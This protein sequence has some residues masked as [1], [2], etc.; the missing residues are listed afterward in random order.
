M[1]T[2]RPDVHEPPPAEEGIGAVASA[3]APKWVGLPGGTRHGAGD[4]AE[5]RLS[6]TRGVK[7]TDPVDDFGLRIPPA[8]NPKVTDWIKEISEGYRGLTREIEWFRVRVTKLV[9]TGKLDPAEKINCWGTSPSSM[10]RSG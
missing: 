6:I 3:S 9:D 1:T 5:A 8:L 2:A 4:G 7:T 10:S